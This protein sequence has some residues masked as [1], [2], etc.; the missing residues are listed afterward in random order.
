MDHFTYVC[1]DFKEHLNTFWLASFSLIDGSFMR[2]NTQSYFGWSFGGKL[3]SG[4]DLK[5]T[6]Q[7]Q[8][9]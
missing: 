3:G 5:A 6:K 2:G 9:D 7:I 4:I 1:Q 8:F